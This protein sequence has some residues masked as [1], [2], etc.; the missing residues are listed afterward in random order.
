MRV[1]LDRDDGKMLYEVDFNSG[2][3]EY[4]YEIDATSGAILESDMDYDD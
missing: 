3:M 2:L 1:K 4:E